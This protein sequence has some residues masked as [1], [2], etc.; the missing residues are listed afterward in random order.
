MKERKE[1]ERRDRVRVGENDRREEQPS[2]GLRVTLLGF[3][4][5]KGPKEGKECVGREDKAVRGEPAL[6]ILSIGSPSRSV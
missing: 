1:S 5:R 6:A 3:I 4:G 2:S